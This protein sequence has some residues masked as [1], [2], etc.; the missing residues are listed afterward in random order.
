MSLRTAVLVELG[1]IFTAAANDT[2]FFSFFPTLLYLV[3]NVNLHQRWL[4][5]SK[6]SHWG[7]HGP[8]PLGDRKQFWVHSFL[9]ENW[10]WSQIMTNSFPPQKNILDPFFTR[11]I[12]QM[13]WLKN[14]IFQTHKSGE[15]NFVWDL[16]LSQQHIF[17]RF[18]N[19]HFLLCF[20]TNINR[21]LNG[22]IGETMN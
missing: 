5:E 10:K 13:F 8:A 15:I 17:A 7:R 18:G 20:T 4:K 21:H 2:K 14:V 22:H 6:T 11:H 12:F 16:S 19:W 9:W 3:A 1:H